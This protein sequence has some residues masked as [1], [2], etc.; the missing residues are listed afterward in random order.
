MVNATLMNAMPEKQMS[1][2][3]DKISR[4][5]EG[6]VLSSDSGGFLQLTT[7]GKPAFDLIEKT[8]AAA[9]KAQRWNAYVADRFYSMYKR[10]TVHLDNLKSY[11]MALEKVR[12]M[13]EVYFQRGEIM[14][15]EKIE[16]IW[17]RY[18]NVVIQNQ[19]NRRPLV[20]VLQ[21]IA[22]KKAAEA[23]PKGPP[24]INPERPAERFAILYCLL[25]EEKRKERGALSKEK[26]EKEPLPKRVSPTFVEQI[27]QFFRSKKEDFSKVPEKVEKNTKRR[28]ERAK[29]AVVDK[30]CN[31]KMF[32]QVWERK[33]QI[34]EESDNTS[35][36]EWSDSESDIEEN[37]EQVIDHGLITRSISVWSGIDAIDQG[38][39]NRE[40]LPSYVEAPKELQSGMKKLRQILSRRRKAITG[41]KSCPNN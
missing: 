35:E 4:W 18:S 10:R 19:S 17:N 28:I 6:K 32:A 1:E 30:I 33:P 26:K 15:A 24:P 14:I 27:R 13:Q 9:L 34:A 21:K 8:F 38:K 31:K 41:A 39:K 20:E 16:G 2:N 29:K 40:P 36:A 25:V 5:Q 12:A 11:S 3:L 23:Q 7:E 37:M 22:Q